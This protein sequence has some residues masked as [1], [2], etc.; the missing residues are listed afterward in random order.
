MKK[1]NGY[2][3]TDIALEGLAEGRAYYRLTGVKGLS[4]KFSKSV[5]MAIREVMKNP[6]AYAIRYRDIRITYAASFPYAI[7]FYVEDDRIVIT[8]I[9]YERR[10]D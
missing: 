3:M 7:H 4:I 2:H 6:G 8:N 10:E 5:Y 1:Y 9:I